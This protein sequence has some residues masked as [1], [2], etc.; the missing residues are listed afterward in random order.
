MGNLVLEL[1]SQVKMQKLISN[2]NIT[3]WEELTNA[4]NL[5]IP[6]IFHTGYIFKVT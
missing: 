4:E 6:Q 5:P 2:I 3:S 1:K